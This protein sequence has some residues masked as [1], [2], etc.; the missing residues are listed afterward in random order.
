M[1]RVIVILSTIILVLTALVVYLVLKGSPVSVSSKSHGLSWT[2]EDQRQLANKLK[3]VGLKNQAIKEYEYYL[4]DAS[5]SRQERANISY[6]LGKMYIEEGEYEMALAWFYQVEIADPNTSLKSELDSKIIKCLES[7]GKYHA[8][9]YALESR[10]SKDNKEGESRGSKVVAEIGKTKIYLSALD[11]SLE[12]MPPWMKQQF[13]GKEKKV[14]YLKKYV[15]DELFYRKALKLEYDKDAEIRRQVE[16]A[17]KELMINKVLED[18]LKDKITIEE[19]DLRNYFEA[20]KKDYAEKA[21]AKISIIK[22]GL[23]EV[24]DEV[25]Q[26]LKKGEDFN[27]LAREIS[28]DK[29]TAPNGGKVNHWIKEGE[30]DLGIGNVKE[31][32]KAIFTSDLGKI[33]PVV[34]AGEYYYII[35]VDEKRPEKMRTFEEC[36]E[37]VKN[38]YYLKK[39]QIAHQNLLEQVLKSSEVKLYPEGIKGEES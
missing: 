4:E 23:K 8:A 35:R 28:L 38:D 33:A 39:L 1:N 22:A 29:N 15:A 13:A 10:A 34:K 26:K 14:E 18:E 25:L 20:H 17:K 31:V 32:S 30:D 37:K 5:L 9:E 27:E 16:R 21:A 7:I 12:S 36:L 19:E 11:E 6:A 2:S 3:S 24:A